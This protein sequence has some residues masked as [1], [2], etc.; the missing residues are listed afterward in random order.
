MVER[1]QEARIAE[2]VVRVSRALAQFQAAR[3]RGLIIRTEAASAS[4]WLAQTER[5]FLVLKALH[6][7]VLPREAD[8]Q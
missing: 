5:E 7:M 8:A 1:S 6:A 4:L 2:Q 3:E